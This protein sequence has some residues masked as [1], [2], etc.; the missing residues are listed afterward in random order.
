M[1]A[2]RRRWMDC[3]CVLDC[4]PTHNSFLFYFKIIFF[5]NSSVNRQSMQLTSA[6][7][8][9]ACLLLDK[10]SRDAD[11]G[12]VYPVYSIE[13]IEDILNNSGVQVWSV[14]NYS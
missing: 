4:R 3:A 7:H 5:M 10:C 8:L 1:N 14:I 6:E 2:L 11:I 12:S 13:E 9:F